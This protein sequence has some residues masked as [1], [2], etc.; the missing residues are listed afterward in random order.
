[1]TDIYEVIRMDLVNSGR[2]EGSVVVHDEVAVTWALQAVK[3]DF[4]WRHER[5]WDDTDY[6]FERG[7]DRYF[8]CVEGSEI[9][10]RRDRHRMDTITRMRIWR[11]TELLLSRYKP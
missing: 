5:D 11:N 9:E 6:R 7:G 1:M 10:F 8:A 4:E 2:S 3:D